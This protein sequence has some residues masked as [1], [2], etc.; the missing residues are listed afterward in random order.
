MKVASQ[1]VKLTLT[2][3]TLDEEG[4][5][6]EFLISETDD[7]LDRRPRPLPPGL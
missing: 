3:V 4:E 5:L 6:V 1:T 7:V 2:P